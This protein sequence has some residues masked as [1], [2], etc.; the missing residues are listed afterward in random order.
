M[1]DGGRLR[2]RVGENIA[3]QGL[4]QAGDKVAVAVSGGLDSVCMLDLLMETR[5]WHGGVFDHGLQ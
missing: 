3:S 1:S 5:A 2:H 4:W